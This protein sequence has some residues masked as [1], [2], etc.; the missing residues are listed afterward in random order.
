MQGKRVYI[1]EVNMVRTDCM[2]YDGDIDCKKCCKHGYI[3][4]CPEPCEDYIDFCGH[5]DNEKG[6]DNNK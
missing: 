2:N 1:S 5:K 3:Y 6:E 4:S